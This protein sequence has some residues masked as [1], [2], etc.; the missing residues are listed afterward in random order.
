[1]TSSGYTATLTHTLNT[2]HHGRISS[3][4][5][6]NDMEIDPAAPRQ[7][8]DNHKDPDPM[9]TTLDPS[10]N[11]EHGQ[12]DPERPKAP[13]DTVQNDY[14]EPPERIQEGR[15]TSKAAERSGKALVPG[16]LCCFAVSLLT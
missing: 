11:H 7:L 3:A 5:Y 13:P 15:H 10:A 16:V 12:D 1:M 8:N 14:I 2:S 6:T 4:R 9:D